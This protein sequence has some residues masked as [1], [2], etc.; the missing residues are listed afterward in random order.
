MQQFGNSHP[1][2][3]CWFGTVNIAWDCAER[4]LGREGG[5]S[6]PEPKGQKYLRREESTSGTWQ[7]GRVLLS[8]PSGA[9]VVHLCHTQRRTTFL[10]WILEYV[11]RR[12]M[13]MC[14]LPYAAPILASSFSNSPLRTVLSTSVLC[15]QTREMLQVQPSTCKSFPAKPTDCPSPKGVATGWYRAA[16]K[17]AVPHL[18]MQRRERR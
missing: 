6:Q 18:C 4:E 3:L 9:C 14:V 5:L 12:R 15:P 13:V 1:H 7:L 17:R 16:C 11:Q 8:L 2:R 10:Q